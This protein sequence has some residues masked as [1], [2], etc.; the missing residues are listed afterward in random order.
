M[1]S[2]EAGVV[3]DHG[4]RRPLL[5]GDPA[6]RR[7]TSSTGHA[8]RPQRA[9]RSKASPGPGLVLSPRQTQGSLG[10]LAEAPER[11]WT[12]WDVQGELNDPTKGYSRERHAEGTLDVLLTAFLRQ[13]VRCG[14]HVGRGGQRVHDAMARKTGNAP[15]PK[16][17]AQPSLNVC[18][19]GEFEQARPP[20]WLLL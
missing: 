14:D 16:G 11:G 3:E 6:R 19:P 15:E 2:D 9:I 12:P 17:K 13:S 5:P 8:C 7:A 10:S 20:T 1:R 18:E 4:L